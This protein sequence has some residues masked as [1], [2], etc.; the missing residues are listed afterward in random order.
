MSEDLETDNNIMS[1][2]DVLEN[3][4]EEFVVLPE[5]DYPFTVT[6]FQ[7]GEFPGSEKTPP[8]PRATLTLDIEN[9]LGKATSR[10][11]LLLCRRHEWKLA[12]F[13]RSIGQKKHGEKMAMNWNRVKGARGR[14]HFKPHEYQK[15]GETRRVNQVDKFLDYDPSLAM[16]PVKPDDLPW[17]NGN[18]G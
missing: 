1:W 11:D 17:S 12:G 13:F 9:D 8:C 3:D 16:T 18:G 6:D 14:A 5:G 7:R 10:T 4:G 2:D 15:N